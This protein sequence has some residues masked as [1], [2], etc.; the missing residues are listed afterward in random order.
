MLKE[1][2]EGFALPTRCLEKFW[3]MEAAVS[4]AALTTKPDGPLPAA[5]G[6]A[7]DGDDPLP[8]LLALRGGGRRALSHPAGKTTVKLAVPQQERGWWRLVA[9]PFGEIPQPVT[10][11][12]CGKNRPVFTG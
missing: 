10:Q 1:L 3:A 5:L 12:Q 7:A 11:L 9:A 6:L 2:R 4:L 8:A